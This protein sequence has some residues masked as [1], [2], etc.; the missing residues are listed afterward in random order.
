MSTPSPAIAVAVILPVLLLAGSNPSPT[1]AESSS[2]LVL[3]ESSPYASPD[4]DCPDT[5]SDNRMYHAF[6]LVGK[7]T[8]FAS[9]I[10]NLCH[11]VHKYQFVVEISLPEPY[12]S[13]LIEERKRY[14]NDSFFVANA[15]RD[16]AVENPV[17]DKMNLPET[18]A[19]LRKS[20]I[21]NVWRGIPYKA[22]Y[23]TWPWAGVKPI[24]SNVP[25]TI[26][27]T[28]HFLPFSASMNRPDRLT[29]LLFGSGAEAHIVHLQTMRGKEPDFD[30]VASLKEP[31][32]WL[33][34]DLLEAGAVID[35]PNE[36]EQPTKPVRCESPFKDDTQIE[37]R[38]RGTDPKNISI[39]NTQFFCTKIANLGRKDP[40]DEAIKCGT[41][42]PK[43]NDRTP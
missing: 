41:E 3:S 43:P 2:P 4:K 30:H 37:V 6:V 17:S 40:C 20:F 15:L 14:P 19:T 18:A 21:G 35:L 42:P 11:E 8:L 27:R 33:P 34:T 1:N 26:E 39:R 28:V 29:Y 22:A 36:E 10:T 24:L 32:E 23:K 5:P 7:D 25:I 13:T 9:H 12:R 16:P 31:P 38:Y